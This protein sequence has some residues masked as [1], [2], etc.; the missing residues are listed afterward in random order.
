MKFLIVFGFVAA[1]GAMPYHG[2]VNTGASAVQ[3]HDD[4]HGNYAFGYNED[5]AYGGTFRKEKGGPGYQVGSYGLRDADGRMRIVEYIA[6]AHGFRAS[7]STNEPGT[8]PKQD[9]AATSL[10]F[11]GHAP[12]PV[13]M[14]PIMEHG[15]VLAAA[16]VYAAEPVY[17][18]TLALPMAGSYSVQHASYLPA[19]ANHYY[20]EP[21]MAGHYNVGHY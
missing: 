17:A 7:I 6:D 20:P 2:L 15:P 16:P 4:G 18:K 8:D 12:G 21:M 11:G 5:H 1:V 3:R 13:P 19:M 9:P 14:A 10:T